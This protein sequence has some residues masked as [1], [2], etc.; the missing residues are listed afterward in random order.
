MMG[1]DCA[2]KCGL[3]P[4]QQVDLG[5]ACNGVPA[6]VAAPLRSCGG[7]VTSTLITLP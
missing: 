2:P 4:N 5:L 7:L 3:T 1:T 6:T